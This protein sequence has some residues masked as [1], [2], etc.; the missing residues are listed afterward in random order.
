MSAITQSPAFH[1]NLSVDSSDKPKLLIIGWVWPEPNSSAAGYRMMQLVALF[2]AEGYQIT[3]ASAAQRSEHMVDLDSLDI[4]CQDIRLNCD[5]FD[6]FV[7]ALSPDVVMYDRYMIEEQF[8]WRVA[9]RCPNAIRIL[10]TEDLQSLRNARH[11]AY[12]AT[13]SLDTTDL[14]T[15]LAIREVAAILRC[16]LTIMISPAEIKLLED[17]YQVPSHLLSYLP[18]FFEKEALAKAVKPYAAREHF[19]SIGNFR[20]APN[21]DSVLWLKQQIWP[22]IRKQLPKAELHIY[23]AYPPKKATDLHCAKSGFF[24]KGWADDAYQVVEQARVLLAPLRF[25]AGIKGKLADAML[26]GTPSVTTDIG[27]EGM[28]TASAWA[29]AVANDVEGIVDNAI[30]LYQS[31]TCW[32]AASQLAEA[33]R[34]TL[35][36]KDGRVTQFF[37]QIAEIDR[38]VEGYRRRNFIGLMLNHH[39]HKSSQYMSQWIA[40]KNASK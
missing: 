40:A 38:D 34:K 36:A 39:S 5:S 18:F 16:D 28:E 14:Q 3:F 9:K 6:T 15:E 37:S 7:E 13:G 11:Q 4:A 19:V 32:Q 24:V 26:C 20:H 12:K 2:Q 22:K 23:G 10:D 27:A 31:E 25:G 33:N 21:W 17:V 29:G 30:E 1:A 8:G 35:F